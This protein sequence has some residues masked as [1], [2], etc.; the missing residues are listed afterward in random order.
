MKKW[1]LSVL[2]LFLIVGYQNFTP[3]TP[4]E[5]KWFQ[6]KKG[7]GISLWA[8]KDPTNQNDDLYAQSAYQRLKLL[9]GQW[10][11]TWSVRPLKYAN[12][13]DNFFPMIWSYSDTY[14]MPLSQNPLKMENQL[15]GIKAALLQDNLLQYERLLLFN[16][17]EH[18][19]NPVTVLS[20]S[21]AANLINTHWASIEKLANI[22]VPPVMATTPLG[23]STGSKW[24]DEFLE[25]VPFS[26]FEQSG[27]VEGEEEKPKKRV[28]PLHIYIDPFN[29]LF[30]S[31]SVDFENPSRRALIQKQIVELFIGEI[32]AI[33]RKYDAAL[34]ITEFGIADWITNK[35]DSPVQRNRIPASFIKEVYLK[36]LPE[37]H[38]RSYVS[39]FA[40]YT[41]HRGTDR[42]TESLRSNAAFKRD[43]DYDYNGD[44]TTGNNLTGVGQVYRDSQLTNDCQY[45]EFINA[46]DKIVEFIHEDCG[47]P[48]MF[49]WKGVGDADNNNGWFYNNQAKQYRRVLTKLQAGYD[50]VKLDGCY[51]D[52]VLDLA[53]ARITERRQDKVGC[54]L[55]ETADWIVESFERVIKP[56]NRLDSPATIVSFMGKVKHYN[57]ASDRVGIMQFP[58]FELLQGGP[59]SALPV[60]RNYMQAILNFIL[61]QAMAATFKCERSEFVWKH[62]RY[63]Q[64]CGCSNLSSD[65][66]PVNQQGAGGRACAHRYLGPSGTSCKTSKFIRKGALYEQAC[67]CSR[68]NPDFYAVPHKGANGESCSHRFL[69]QVALKCEKTQFHWE[70]AVYEQACGCSRLS[71]G[72]YRVSQKGT[73]GQACFHKA[74]KPVAT[75]ALSLGFKLKSNQSLYIGDKI[76]LV[77]QNDGN[78]VFYRDGK[79]VW[80]SATWG[81][82]RADCLA[83]FQTDGNF[84]IYAQNGKKAVYVSQ[85]TWK[86]GTQ[87]I[88]SSSAP[89]LSIAD[90]SNTVVWTGEGKLLP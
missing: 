37:L 42:T 19:S 43:A 16:E 9:N 12:I 60:Q 65:F 6:K 86:R 34:M 15:E 49:G 68:L 24:T 85:N 1:A 4:E 82:C 18:H 2:G 81:R 74:L 26:K 27:R 72:Y 58:I 41:N 44:P 77:M 54:E 17:P 87:L 50:A 38:R 29:E 5:E 78:L 59:S 62:G 35:A 55:P 66:Y 22:I 8:E 79:A 64:A 46:D 69:N 83:V 63:E 48:T 36:L 21:D 32:H 57:L 13:N 23:N 67:G 45:G 71:A 47:R 40:L 88:L 20:P 90:K 14:K 89:Y 51:R 11:Y 61:P 10:Y 33:K 53:N 76:F 31:S 80:A 3:K 28:V 70:G 7:V 39:H 30:A 73:Q 84:V 75:K 56:P 25:L 52:R